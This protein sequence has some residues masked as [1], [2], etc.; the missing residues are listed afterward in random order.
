[1]V[2]GPRSAGYTAFFGE[3]GAR[4]GRTPAYSPAP[5]MPVGA[6]DGDA[7]HG[8]GA[9]ARSWRR[10][11][12]E[13][14]KHRANTATARPNAEHTFA[15]NCLARTRTLFG[16]VGQGRIPALISARSAARSI[17]SNGIRPSFGP[18]PISHPTCY[19]FS[20]CLCRVGDG[21]SQFWPKVLP[22]IW[23][24]FLKCY[25]AVCHT[26]N[27]RTPGSRHRSPT[28]LPFV[29]CWWGDA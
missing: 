4:H 28:S 16:L 24:Q 23:A 11:R 8:A 9:C 29:H 20:S 13:A 27:R 19:G 15:R 1:M 18:A 6:A 22:I 25:S 7:A 10:A 5:V 21:W 12:V 2:S 3:H 14:A 26:D 17:R